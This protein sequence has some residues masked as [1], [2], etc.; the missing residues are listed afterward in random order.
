MTNISS[1][2]VVEYTVKELLD[3]QTALLREIDK[4]VDTKA[5]REDVHAIGDRVDKLETRTQALEVHA[6]SWKTVR[7]VRDN[8]KAIWI[9]ICSVG[10]VIG[11]A[12]L[13]ALIH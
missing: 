2:S 6:E 5:T 8:S 10:A 7:Q 12:V 13:G 9:G 11:G 1:Q 3:E 4:K